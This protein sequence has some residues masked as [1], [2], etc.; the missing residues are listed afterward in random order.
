MLPQRE[1]KGLHVKTSKGI[2]AVIW[3]ITTVLFTQKTTYHNNDHFNEVNNVARPPM[4]LVQRRLTT[5][6]RS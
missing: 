5:V 1:G 3:V 4:Y 6:Y 2:T